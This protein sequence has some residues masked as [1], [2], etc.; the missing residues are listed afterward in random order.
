[1]A[2]AGRDFK[3]HQAPNPLPQAG[4]PTSISNTRPGYPGPHPTCFVTSF[5]SFQN[6]SQKSLSYKRK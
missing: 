1:M 5:F 3:D 4:P 2:W 6:E